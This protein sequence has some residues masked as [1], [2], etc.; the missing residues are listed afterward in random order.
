MVQKTEWGKI[1]FII[2]LL[3]RILWSFTYSVMY[4]EIIRDEKDLSRLSDEERKVDANE[5]M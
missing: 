3:R 4:R 1:G 5:I 2:L